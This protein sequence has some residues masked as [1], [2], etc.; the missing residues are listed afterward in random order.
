MS[1]LQFIADVIYGLKVEYGEPIVV[2]SH[3][4]TIEQQTGQKTDN[5]ITFPICMAI[6]LPEN[7]REAFLKSVGIKKEGM[8][9]AGQ[10]Q[11]LIDKADIPIGMSIVKGG[12]IQFAGKTADIQKVDDY[13]HAVT[14]IVQ[15]L[16]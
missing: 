1:N 16:T 11:F 6:P 10:R 3:V 14:L 5:P 2:G 9:E 12:Y 4:F 7:L 15:G 13:L 8:L